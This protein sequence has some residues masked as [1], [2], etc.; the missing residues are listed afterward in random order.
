M[1]K[2]ILLTHP[3]I[4][5]KDNIINKIKTEFSIVRLISVNDYFSPSKIVRAEYEQFEWI[6]NWQIYYTKLYEQRASEGVPFRDALDIAV[7]QAY[8]V[9]V[10]HTLQIDHNFWVRSQSWSG[11]GEGWG[12]GIVLKTSAPLKVRWRWTFLQGQCN[13]PPCLG[14][15][16]DAANSSESSACTE[17][18]AHQYFLVNFLKSCFTVSLVFRHCQ[19]SQSHSVLIWTLHNNRFYT[20]P[21]N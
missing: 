7:S 19:N 2:S 1:Y 9:H 13:N 20:K 5:Y 17:I 16:F 11:C 21:R 15:T 18:L 10:H 3:V 6:V 8:T 12:G 4:V 14:N